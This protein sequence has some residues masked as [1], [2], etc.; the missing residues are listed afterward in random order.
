LPIDRERNRVSDFP[1]RTFLLPT[2][3][4]NGF[5]AQHTAPTNTNPYRSYEP[6]N[7]LQRRNSSMKQLD[8]AFGIDIHVHGNTLVNVGDKVT[9]NIPNI[10][11]V[12]DGIE[13]FDRF[14]KGPFLIKT[15]RH[16]FNMISSPRKHEMH[17]NLV[18]DSLEEELDSPID[19]IESESEK[20]AIIK[21][22]E[23]Q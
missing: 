17:M 12:D 2:S 16:D 8:G 7:W 23:Y 15:I 10:S 14:F 21:S 20:A 6:E 3:T 18:K 5:D 1:A 22:I 11:A 4:S 19:N 13:V 9:V